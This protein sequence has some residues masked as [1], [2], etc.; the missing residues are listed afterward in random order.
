VALD[1]QIEALR[2]EVKALIVAVVPAGTPVYDYIRNVNHEETV[3]S[4]MKD[5][6]GKLHF[7][8]FGLAPEN[9]VT[10]EQLPGACIRAT[11]R[12][13]LH[14]YLALQDL[15]SPASEKVLDGEA[16]DVIDGVEAQRNVPGSLIRGFPA[17]RVQGGH[18]ALVNVLCNYARLTMASL[19]H[20]GV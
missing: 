1:T 20:S 19:I 16:A 10:V 8:Q 18:V 6:G 17:Q 14:G 9:P 7:W 12:L 11:V 15:T 4:I 5:T 13:D 3:A 2:A